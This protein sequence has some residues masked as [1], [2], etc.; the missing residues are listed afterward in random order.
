MNLPNTDKLYFVP[1]KCELIRNIN[2]EPPAL[3]K[4]S[5]AKVVADELNRML[6][7]SSARGGKN[8]EEAQKISKDL[9]E[10]LK[11]HVDATEVG[12]QCLEEGV[13][14]DP[15]WYRQQLNQQASIL[16]GQGKTVRIEGTRL[17]VTN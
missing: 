6:S 8:F 17:I 14:M 10:C 4:C 15:E 5:T 11:T 13:K 2:T 9:V 16:R 12:I 1:K 3:K 7:E